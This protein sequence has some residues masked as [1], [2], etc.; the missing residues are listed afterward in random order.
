MVSK[1][2][3]ECGESIRN[4]L[5]N[6][7]GGAESHRVVFVDKIPRNARDK[8]DRVRLREIS[9]EKYAEDHRNNSS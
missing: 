4:L 6:L 8:I 9:R 2:E 3:K 5:D 1:N 7:T